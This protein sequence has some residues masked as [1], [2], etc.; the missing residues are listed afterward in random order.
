MEIK[1]KSFHLTATDIDK[2]KMKG[3]ELENSKSTE[4]QN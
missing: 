2:I 1:K 3:M 4:Q